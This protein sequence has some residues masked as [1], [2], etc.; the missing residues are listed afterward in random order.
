M[1]WFL[2]GIANFQPTDCIA[3][4][5]RIMSWVLRS[6]QLGWVVVLALGVAA[7]CAATAGDGGADDTQIGN[8]AGDDGMTDSDNGNGGGGN[9]DSGG[10]SSGGGSEGGDGPGDGGN[11][12]GDGGEVLPI[13]QWASRVIDFSSQF[14]Q[15]GWSP[16]QALGEPDVFVYGDV[17]RAWAPLSENGTLEFI[18]VGFDRAVFAT[19]VTIRE[20]Y[21]N[22]MVIEVELIDEQGAAH[23]IWADDDPSQPGEPVDFA[24]NWTQTEFAV[25]GVRVH[26]DTD[27]NLDTW[28]EIDAIELR[29]IPAD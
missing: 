1:I 17:L 16:Q 4:T 14:G 29:G 25:N 2:E 10:G 9:G 15:D 7:G 13:A 5:I 27:A 6:I 26:I 18:A 28:E 23:S 24:I 11:G 22:G 21:G 8:F 20:T 12:S 3:D 19:G